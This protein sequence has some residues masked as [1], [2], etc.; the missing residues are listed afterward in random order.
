LTGFATTYAGS[1]G[2]NPGDTLNPDGSVSIG[3]LPANPANVNGAEPAANTP[4]AGASPDGI[5]VSGTL[6]GTNH[7]FQQ[8]SYFN[9][10]PILNGGNTSTPLPDF[11]ASNTPCTT[12]NCQQT[13]YTPASGP[14]FN[15]LGDGIMGNE[16]TNLDNSNY[17]YSLSTGTGA[18]SATITI[19]VGIFG[20]TNV[21]T[22]L[23]TAGGNTTGGTLGSLLGDSAY[24]SITFTFNSAADGSGTADGTETLLLVNGVTQRNI[25]DGAGAG[26]ANTLCGTNSSITGSCSYNVTDP[27]NSSTYAVVVG[28]EWN[29]SANVGAA[30]GDTSTMV[31]DYQDF[32]IFS[33]YQG[34][35]LTSVSITDTGTASGATFSREVLSGVTVDTISS[36]PEPSTILML[37]GGFGVIAVVSFRRR[38]V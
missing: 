25:M 15:L 35:Y 22:M 3:L 31:L 34:A 20:V 5:T 13:V 24:A 19:P 27:N 28:N 21:N 30:T 8:R 17:W 10:V 38:R 14:T 12:G 7:N 23:N 1:L 6:N 29:S 32:P 4:G 26:Y 16:F 37:L 36:A 33:E 11:K 2:I 9:A 18:N